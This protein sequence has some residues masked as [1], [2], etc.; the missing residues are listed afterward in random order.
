MLIATGVIS[1]VMSQSELYE[2]RGVGARVT[3]IG[4]FNL[5]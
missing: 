5:L 4:T 1:F 3:S 2:V